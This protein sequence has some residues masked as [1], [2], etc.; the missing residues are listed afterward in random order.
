MSNRV[1][2]LRLTKFAVAVIVLGII[3]SGIIDSANQEV[4]YTE[5]V[6]YTLDDNGDNLHL[7]SNTTKTV[8]STRTLNTFTYTK[9]T[10][11]TDADFDDDPIQYLEDNSLFTVI[12]ILLIAMILYQFRSS[13][14]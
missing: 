1:N 6:V 3:V 11:D 14:K 9:T 12:V 5:E 4:V 10:S 2:L 7:N 8:I 13:K